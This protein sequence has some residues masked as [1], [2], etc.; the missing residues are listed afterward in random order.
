MSHTSTTDGG[1]ED[2]E[3]LSFVECTQGFRVDCPRAATGPLEHETIDE[4]SHAAMVA[5]TGAGIGYSV[6]WTDLPAKQLAQPPMTTLHQI[7]K[8]RLGKTGKVDDEREMSLPGGEAIEFSFHR[9]EDKK[10]QAASGRVL[11]FLKGPTLFQ[12]AAIGD[13]GAGARPDASLFVMS[14]RPQT[15]RE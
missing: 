13:A 4:G 11:L 14:F 8:L 5:R 2:S 15:C 3:E 12:V 9:A 1:A 10:E 6:T 7:E